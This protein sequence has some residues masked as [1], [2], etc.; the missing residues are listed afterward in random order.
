MAAV[1][2]PRDARPLTSREIAKVLLGMIS[3]A[4]TH[5]PDARKQIP[6]ALECAKPGAIIELRRATWIVAFRAT[7][8][9]LRGWCDEREVNTAL[10]WLSE[11]HAKV[12]PSS[13]GPPVT[14]MN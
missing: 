11:N 10:T 13:G 6:R 12:I 2:D 3:G 1:L 9:G 4:V 7:V 5:D 8:A 14:P